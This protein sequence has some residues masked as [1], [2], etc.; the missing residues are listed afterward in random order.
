MDTLEENKFV[1]LYKSAILE[2]PDSEEL[3]D[4][5]LVQVNVSLRNCEEFLF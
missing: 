5:I 4:E 2:D 1:E 3:K